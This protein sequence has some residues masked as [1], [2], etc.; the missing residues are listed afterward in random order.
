MDY[1]HLLLYLRVQSEP[2]IEYDGEKFNP[3]RVVIFKGTEV[4]FKNLSAQNFWPATNI[5]PLNLLYSEFNASSQIGPG[6]SWSFVFEKVGEWDYHD[7]LNPSMGGEIIVIDR[8]PIKKNDAC[9]KISELSYGDR[10]VCWYFEMKK[11][12]END[13]VNE[14]FD[15]LTYLFSTEPTFASG[16]HD[17]THIIGIVAY[18]KFVKGEQ[19]K[20]EG[21]TSYCG[22]GYYHGFIQAMLFS[23]GD[24][25]QAKEFCEGA[26]DSLKSVV[27]NSNATYAC[28]HGMGHSMFDSH[29][30]NLWGDEEKMLEPAF[31]ICEQI[32]EGVEEGKRRMCATGI[33]NA[34][35]LAYTG[36]QYG[37]EMNASDPTWI[38]RKQPELYKGPCFIEVGIA[39]VMKQEGAL[40]YD[41]DKAAAFVNSIDDPIGEEV[42]AFTLGSEYIRVH[43][44]EFSDGSDMI[45]NC[46][47][48]TGKNNDSC[49]SGAVL[50]LIN[51]GLRGEE[52]KDALSFCKNDLM[53]ERQRG[54]CFDYFLPRLRTLYLEEKADEVCALA[55]QEYRHLCEFTT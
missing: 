43:R 7:H 10:Q 50:G 5:H 32:T 18:E 20:Y 25:E 30:P 39:W 35:G 14:A 31:A 51:W 4:T 3:G 36:N 45:E 8:D 34:L 38:C 15:H 37:L 53:S 46:N 29:S 54:A 17:V 13:G 52:F 19:L 49:I 24:Y 48:F 23:T 16:C 40:D 33:F 26:D 28:Y 22:Y 27:K 21:D 41:F 11:I 6:D 42:S 9:S 1:K 55:D 2:I 44:S 47:L 12:I